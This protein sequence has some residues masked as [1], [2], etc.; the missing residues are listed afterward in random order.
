MRSIIQSGQGI[1]VIQYGVED[2]R[3]HGLAI[4]NLTSQF[5]ANTTPPIFTCFS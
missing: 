2:L 1:H 5:W 3:P 4:G